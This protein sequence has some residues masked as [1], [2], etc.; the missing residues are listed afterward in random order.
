[1]G[2]SGCGGAAFAVMMHHHENRSHV[3]YKSSN[4]NEKNQYP[5]N[6]NT[7]NVSNNIEKNDKAK[8]TNYGCGWCTIL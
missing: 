5:I 8:G 3:V 4:Y 7:E 1:M 6:H 2:G